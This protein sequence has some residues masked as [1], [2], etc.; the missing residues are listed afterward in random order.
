LH[1]KV[2]KFS[3]GTGSPEWSRKKGRKTVV[4]W[5]GVVVDIPDV[6]TYA[7]FGEDE[8]RLRGLGV[9]WGQ[10]SPLTLIVALTTLSHY[11]ASV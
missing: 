5:C 6:I 1:H 3:S 7:N 8:D 10:F 2:Q 11:R 9:A 4:E